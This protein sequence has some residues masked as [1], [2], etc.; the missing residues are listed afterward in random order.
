MEEENNMHQN[1]ADSLTQ[2]VRSLEEIR[3]QLTRANEASGALARYDALRQE[4]AQTG[5]AAVQEKYHPDC[6]TEDPAAF[7][8]FAFC[9]FV[10]MSMQKGK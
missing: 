2:A 7:A 9:R 8:L 6:N 4:I 5:F 10:H 1:S 3:E